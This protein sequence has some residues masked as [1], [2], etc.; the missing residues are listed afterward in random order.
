MNRLVFD[1][2]PQAKG[3]PRFGNGR[4]FTPQRT[5]DFEDEIRRMAKE[6]YKQAP[7]TGAVSL[8]VTFYLPI[9]MSWSKKKKENRI[10]QFHASRPDLDNLLKGVLDALNGVLYNSDAQVVKLSAAKFYGTQPRIEVIFTIMDDTG[11]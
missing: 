6:Q 4:T 2:V 10:G 1:I 3:R 8:V 7:L 5:R 9:P 11:G